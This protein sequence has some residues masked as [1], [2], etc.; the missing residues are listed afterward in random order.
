MKVLCSKTEEKNNKVKQNT[1]FLM[2]E[3]KTS[4]KQKRTKVFNRK[5]KAQRQCK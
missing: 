3:Q 2:T 1:E 5:F 4:N